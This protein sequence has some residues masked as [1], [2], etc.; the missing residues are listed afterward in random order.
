MID[1][2]APTVTVNQGA[3]QADPTNVSPVSFDVVFS[4]P[5]T[6]FDATDV[7]IGGT[8]STGAPTVTPLSSTNYTITVPV[9]GDGTIT[10]SVAANKAQD[11]ANNGNT[12]ST[13]T[14]NSVTFDTT[15]PTVAVDQPRRLEPDE[16][17]VGPVH[18]DVQRTRLGRRRH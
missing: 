15:A 3:G 17:H 10:A 12:A 8:A 18:G 4:E 2:V 5:V 11:A 1:G 6:G 9:L 13:S 16:R 7:T 14:D